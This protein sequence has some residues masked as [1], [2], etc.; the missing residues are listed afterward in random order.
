LVEEELAATLRRLCTAEFL[1][2]TALDPVEEYRFWHPLTQEVAYG[3]LLRERRAALHGAVARAIIAAEPDR[4]DERAALLASHFERSGDPLEAARWNDRAAG[5]A[6]RTDVAEAMRRWRATLAHLSSAPET[7]EALRIGIRARNRL[8]RYG[9]RTGMDL[10]EAGRLYAEGKAVAER[11]QDAL[12]LA[13]VTFALASTLFFRGTVRE[14]IDRYIEAA[15]LADQT[16]DTDAQ[17]GYGVPP[18]LVYTWVGPVP[19]GLEATERLATLCGGDA[20]VGVSVLGFSTLSALGVARAELLCLCGRVTEA[21]AALDDGLATARARGESEWIAWALS[22]YPRLARTTDEFEASLKR[23]HEAVRIADDSGN[24]SGHVQ[25]L[26]ALGVAEIGLG[27]HPEAA[28]TLGQALTEARQ[29]QVALF[30]EARILVHLAQARLARG[31]HGQAR[32]TAHEAVEV[33]QRQGARTVECLA[34]LTRARILRATGATP[35][36]IQSDLASALI[37][38]RETGATAYQDE[39]EAERASVSGTGGG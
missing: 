14:G 29:R 25:A 23:A 37:L 34:R 13:S 10:D 17:A 24:A 4:L 28:E 35:E 11:L 30:E 8:I 36:E 15:R 20:S 3:G 33:A 1:Q 38:A 2:E 19:E 22:V 5:F 27:R 18:A 26:G 16:D 12:Q 7:D 32:E 6:L 39:I 21:R 31:D 9:A